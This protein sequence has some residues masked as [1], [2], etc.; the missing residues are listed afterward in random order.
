MD[1]GGSYKKNSI[2]KE[3]NLFWQSFLG[4]DE[5]LAGENSEKSEIIERIEKLNQEQI[6]DLARALSRD[7]KVINQKLEH[8]NKEIELNMAKLDSL[9]LVG[10]DVE[11][12]RKR[13]EALHDLG[14]RLTNSLE[15]VDLK[16]KAIRNREIALQEE[17]EA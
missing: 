4:E 14:Q 17:L 3:W 1:E 7:R 2:L 10:G 15:K 9:E 6:K 16:M 11:D 5:P 13:M 12:V 8:L